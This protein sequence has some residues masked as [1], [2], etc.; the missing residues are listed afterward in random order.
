MSQDDNDDERKLS[1]DDEKKKW[2]FRVDDDV[3]VLGDVMSL[4]ICCLLIG[5][6]N[7]IQ[8]PE[9]LLVGG[10]A[11]PIPAVPS[12]VG[13]T[14]TK[15]SHMGVSWL[16]A[17]V[18]NVSFTYSAVADR[19]SIV[20]SIISTWVTFCSI[21]II[22]AIS[23]AAVAGF[24]DGILPKPVDSIDLFKSLIAVLPGLFAWR[25]LFSQRI[26]GYF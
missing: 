21:E 25:I 19:P 6:F 26:N 9:F 5:M 10:W 24:E 8:S 4:T 12:T 13:A 11:A 15:A 3:L 17:G 23:L 22:L 1:K 20:K 16:L 14:I 18:Y 2:E 7:V